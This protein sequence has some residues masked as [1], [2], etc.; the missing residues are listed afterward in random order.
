MAALL[1]FQNQTGGSPPGVVDF[2]TSIMG[3]VALAVT[4]RRREEFIGNPYDGHTLVAQMKQ[5]ESLIGSKVSVAHVD[6]G[7]R[8]HDYEGATTVHVDKR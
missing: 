2:S 4:V 6:I 5:V 8:D 1:C 7:Y 3:I